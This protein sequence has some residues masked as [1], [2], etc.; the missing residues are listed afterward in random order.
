MKTALKTG[1]RVAFLA[2][3]AS[4][5]LMPTLASAVEITLTSEDGSVVLTGEFMG[6]RDFAYVID[7]DGMELRIPVAMM[8]CEGPA[9]I[10]VEPSESDNG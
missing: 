10:S 9:C 5:A 4:L 7:Y 2:T 8:N 6:L 1:T 3:F